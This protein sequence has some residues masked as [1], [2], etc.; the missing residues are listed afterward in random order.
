MQILEIVE[1]NFEIIRA[2]PYQ[3]IHL[4]S[5]EYHCMQLLCQNWDH[6]PGAFW[7][8]LN[9]ALTDKSPS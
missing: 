5:A 6:L 1:L 2:Q 4:H 9:W 3:V 7:E 8:L